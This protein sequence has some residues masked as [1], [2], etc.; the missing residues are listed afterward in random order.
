M[1]IRGSGVSSNRTAGDELALLRVRLFLSLASPLLVEGSPSASH[2][3]LR[4]VKAKFAAMRI[5]QIEN[6]NKNR[7]HISILVH[8]TYLRIGS[9]APSSSSLCSINDSSASKKQSP[10]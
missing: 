8:G 6:E 3:S 10:S 5:I 1:N 9:T 4:F 7:N 2:S